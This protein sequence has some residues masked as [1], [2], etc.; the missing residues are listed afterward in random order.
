MTAVPISMLG[1]EPLAANSNILIGEYSGTCPVGT[2]SQSAGSFAKNVK[3]CAKPRIAAKGAVGN[4][5]M[6]LLV[7][8][9]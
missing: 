9:Q 7:S 1:I 5:E 3:F 2:C 6:I 8:S 4:R